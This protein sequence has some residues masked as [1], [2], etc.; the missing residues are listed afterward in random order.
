MFGLCLFAARFPIIRNWPLQWLLMRKMISPAAAPPTGA[1]DP[2]SQEDPYL[3]EIRNLILAEFPPLP[4]G[5]E[6]PAELGDFSPAWLW[7]ARAGP[8]ARPRSPP[9]R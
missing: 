1:R 3:D 5:T 6:P 9:A 4:A 8:A 2:R 7:L